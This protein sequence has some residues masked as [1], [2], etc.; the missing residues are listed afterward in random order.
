MCAA[1]AGR[2][3]QGQHSL[4]PSM[5]VCSL[6][7]KFVWGDRRKREPLPIDS[8]LGE[9]L[10]LVR[11]CRVV[12]CEA[13]TGAGKTT[14]IGQAAILSNVELRVVMT[15]TRR[16]ACRWNGKRIAAEIGCHPGQV[17]GWSLSGEDKMVSQATRLEL[18]VDQTLANRIR[19]KGH[20]PKGLVIVDEAHER[21]L[22]IDLLLGLIKELLEKSSETSILIMSATID[23]KKF[24]QFFGGA[25]IIHIEG[26]CHPVFTEIVPLL[27]AEHH[28]AGAA[29]AACQVIDRFLAE[30]LYIPQ[31]DK[32]REVVKKGS[33]LIL[34][35][36]KEDID[37]VMVQLLHKADGSEHIQIYACHGQSSVEEQEQIQI[38]IPPQTLRVICCTELLRSSMTV[39]ETVGVIDSLQIKRRVTD[40]NGVSHLNKI[41]ISKA[42]AKQ[43]EG[44]AGR[45]GPGFYMPISFGGEFEQLKEW[46]EP[47]IQRESLTRVALE[48]A[49]LGRSIR[50]FA[51]IDPPPKPQIELAIRRLQLLGALSEDES[52]TE[53]GKMLLRFPLDPEQAK[54][55][56]TAHRLGV[57]SE[58]LIVTAFLEVEDFFYREKRERG[59][60]GEPPRKLWAGSSGNDFVAIVHGYRAFKSFEGGCKNKGKGRERTLEAWCSQHGFKYKQLRLA[61]EKIKQIL[62]ELTSTDLRGEKEYVA[63]RIFSEKALT[64]ALASGKVDHLAVL[65]P[66]RERTYASPLGEFKLAYES[67]CSETLP[68]ILVGGVRKIP[69]KGM[70]HETSF[71]LLADLATP[72][73][74]D[75]LLE[76]VPHLCSKKRQKNIHYDEKKDQVLETEVIWFQESKIAERDILAEAAEALPIF[77][78]WL[79]DQQRS[80]FFATT[81]PLNLT[82][83]LSKNAKENEMA[84]QLNLRAGQTLFPVF[85]NEAIERYFIQRL[86]GKSRIADLTDPTV[87][88]L[89]KFDE[90]MARKVLKE[91]PAKIQ[92]GSHEYVIEYGKNPRIQVG[93]PLRQWLSLFVHP[94]HLPSHR[95]VEVVVLLKEA[96]CILKWGS[97]GKLDLSH[98]NLSSEDLSGLNLSGINLRGSNL[99]GTIFPFD[100]AKNI[101]LEALP[102]L[103]GEQDL[104]DTQR[105]WQA[106]DNCDAITHPQVAYITWSIVKQVIHEATVRKSPLLLQT[107]STH[108]MVHLKGIKA[109]FNLLTSL[110]VPSSQTEYQLEINGALA[111]LSLT[112]S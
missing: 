69:I 99:Q 61:E 37:W 50:H 74:V 12:I 92:I 45:T 109:A 55:L 54:V 5:D 2:T 67:A 63:E 81:L 95:A 8:R 110:F 75:W 64:Q 104:T 40:A 85:S 28:T 112:F 49:S 78:R 83:V 6:Q 102:L 65:Q 57:F 35:P 46:P 4:N 93:L 14:R 39:R 59:D 111:R 76:I 3:L 33:V 58:A 70:H 62:D 11:R 100:S 73:E 42:E 30:N 105:L 51:L 32:D 41:P 94:L 18:I 26:R 68:L 24:S 17:V 107:L 91:N 106:L 38:P 25:P 43:G 60:E 79:F 44:R 31:G 53:I 10:G 47:A 108:P 80:K 101:G 7:E 86:V 98:Q 34:L 1:A 52:I 16:T 103:L 19:S 77:A 84:R 97:N 21:S 36:G 20:L 96:P 66:Y 22:S 15:Q 72:I 56:L 48:I 71:F 29:R 90:Q 88:S 27:H 89:P 23:A 13:E 82:Q 87:L 9:I